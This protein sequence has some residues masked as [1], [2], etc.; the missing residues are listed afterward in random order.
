MGVNGI[1]AIEKDLQIKLATIR[2]DLQKLIIERD[3]IKLELQKTREE[4]NDKISR[5][6]KFREE[7]K[8]VR[9]ELNN[10]YNSLNTLKNDLTQLR[11]KLREHISQAKKLSSDLKRISSLATRESID[12]MREEIE[13]LEWT[14]ITTPNLT[15]EEEKRIVEKIA[16]LEKKMKEIAIYQRD[17]LDLHTKYEELSLEIDNLKKEIKERGEA[18]NQVREKIT[19]LKNVREKLRKDII[20]TINSIAELKKKRDELK[21]KLKEVINAINE[22]SKEY[23]EILK[24]LNSVRERKE[25]SKT[26]LILKRKKEEVKSKF[27]RGERITLYELYLMYGE[28]E[29]T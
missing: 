23:K 24:E 12:S 5:L 4:L 3:S 29:K 27:E 16:Q 18:L 14:L 2:E 7:L 19:Q 13:K 8:K 17:V 25:H 20:E 28:E 9:E 11:G 6:R 22:K 26:S 1:G 21:S 15:S 10:H